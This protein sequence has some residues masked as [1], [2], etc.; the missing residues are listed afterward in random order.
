MK[1]HNNHQKNNP[2]F[3]GLFFCIFFC[4][5]KCSSDFFGSDEMH[6]LHPTDKY[7][8]IFIICESNRRLIH[9]SE[10]ILES[11]LERKYIIPFSIIMF[12]RIFCIYPIHFCCLDDTIT[13]ELKSTKDSSRVST[14]IRIPRTSNRDDNSSFFEMPEGSTTDKILSHTMGWDRRHH[15]YS[16]AL[17]FYRLTDCN[18]VD[19]RAEHSHIIPRCTIKPTSFQLDPSDNISTT[20]DDH[21]L[22]LFCEKREKLWIYSISLISLKCLTRKLEKDTFWGVI[23]FHRGCEVKKK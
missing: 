12:F 15:S 1:Y 18:S 20:H 11:F 23:F 14:K 22:K 2:A 8:H 6:I 17:F 9:H 3:A 13:L 10:I 16:D 5:D 19:N 21:D 7:W 4:M